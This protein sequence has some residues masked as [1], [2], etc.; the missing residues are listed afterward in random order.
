MK[1]YSRFV[2]N[3]SS[4]FNVVIYIYLDVILSVST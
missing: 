1:L 3:S 2:I 4:H